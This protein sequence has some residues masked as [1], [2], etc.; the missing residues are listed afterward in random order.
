[1]FVNLCLHP[2]NVGGVV[3]PPSGEAGGYRGCPDAGGHGC[4][5]P[6][7]VV[8]CGGG[9]ACSC[10]WYV[11]PCLWGGLPLRSKAAVVWLGSCY[12]S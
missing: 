11:V 6:S 5:G 10:G 7:E 9:L 1:M 12:F 3:V 2:V 8:G 4:S